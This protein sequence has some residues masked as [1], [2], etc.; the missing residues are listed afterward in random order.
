MDRSAE[1]VGNEARLASYFERLGVELGPRGSAGAVW[2]SMQRAIFPGE[3]KSIEPI[4]ARVEPRRVRGTHQ[5]AVTFCRERRLVPGG[6]VAAGSAV[7]VARQFVGNSNSS[8][9]RCCLTAKWDV[10]WR[11]DVDKTL[12][13]L[14]AAVLMSSCRLDRLKRNLPC[15]PFSVSNLRVAFG[16]TPIS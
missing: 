1:G 14:F 8:P 7:G 5:I 10:V 15:P 4:A 12:R 16:S 2:L 13:S 9:S 3:R 6:P 11:E